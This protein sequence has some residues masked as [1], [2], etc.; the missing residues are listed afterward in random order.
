MSTRSSCSPEPTRPP[1]SFLSRQPPPGGATGSLRP[2]RLSPVTVPAPSLPE[3]SER[4]LPPAGAPVGILGFLAVLVALAVSLLAAPSASA[5]P[6]L[7]ARNAV[8][9]IAAPITQRVGPHEP[10]LPGESRQRAPGY[11]QTAVASGV[12]AEAAA[13]APLE[14]AN[15]ETVN[16]AASPIRSFVTS[17]EQTYYRV[18]SGERTV[19][20]YLIGAPPANADEAVAGLALPPGNTASF[21]QEVLVPAGTR[22]Q[23]SIAAE[24]FGQPGG[25]LQFEILDQI[26]IKNFG[27]GIPFR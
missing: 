1:R 14:L 7:R 4:R 2:E 6:L 22:L 23:S 12:G 18:F 9:P 8:A 25:P 19:G 20:A 21:I 16:N 15:P 11:H 3:P 10:K 27:E 26:P 13:S 17:E 5:A 24:A